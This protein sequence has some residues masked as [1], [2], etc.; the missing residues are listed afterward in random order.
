VEVGP[1]GGAGG[2]ERTDSSTIEDLVRRVERRESFR[3]S[4]GFREGFGW[5]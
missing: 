2:G 3:V 4:R 1:G 5:F